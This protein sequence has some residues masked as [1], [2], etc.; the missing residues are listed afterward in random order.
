L[1]GWQVRHSGLSSGRKPHWADWYA[2]KYAGKSKQQKTKQI[3]MVQKAQK[4]RVEREKN[5]QDQKLIGSDR[6][7]GTVECMGW[8]L[9]LHAAL[10]CHIKLADQK[11]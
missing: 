8:F 4:G 2:Q 3:G 5:K 11:R 10:G 1:T 7:N 6:M 9:I